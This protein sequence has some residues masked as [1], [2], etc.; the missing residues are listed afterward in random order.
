MGTEVLSVLHD[1]SLENGEEQ[2]AIQGLNFANHDLHIV[3]PPREV[4]SEM[5]SI[6]GDL[7]YEIIFL[8]LEE[9][10]PTSDSIS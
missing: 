7:C 8:L 9:I 3:L 2:S 6:H 4:E 5:Y 10:T 1:L